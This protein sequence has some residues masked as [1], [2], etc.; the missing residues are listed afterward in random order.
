MIERSLIDGEFLT[1]SG[2]DHYVESVTT[3]AYYVA[4]AFRGTNRAGLVA[5]SSLLRDQ[6]RKLELAPRKGIGLL[7]VLGEVAEVVL[8]NSTVVSHPRYA[9]HLHCP[10]TVSSL[11]AETVI[12]ALNQSMDSYDQGPVATVIEQY[13]VDWICQLLGY[14]SGEGVFT[15][16]ATQSN[17]Q[18]LLLA[19]DTYAREH[20][21]WNTA[22][23]GLPT[24]ARRWRII[25]TR[26]THFTVDLAAR[27]LG[28]GSASIVDA[29]TDDQ[30]RLEPRSLRS[31]IQRCH[32]ARLPVIAVVLNAGTTDRGVIDPLWESCMIAQ[33][34]GIWVHVDA[35]AGG[36]LMFS[37]KHR[38][39]LDGISTSDA[40]AID[41]HKLLFQSISCGALL[42]RRCWTLETLTTHVDYL[43]PADDD[44]CETPNLVGK[45]LQTTRRFDALKV[46]VTLRALGV[47]AIAHMIECTIEA[48]HAASRAAAGD[49]RLRVIGKA[50]TNT[51]LIRW[52]SSALSPQAL[53]R[54][55]TMVCQRLT[56]DGHALI[57]RTRVKQGV[58]LKLTFVNPICTAETAKALVEEIA[59]LGDSIARDERRGVIDDARADTAS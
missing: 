12:S 36:C 15:S 44:P 18:A 56:T 16:G 6:I 4:N 29:D 3:A 21:S 19:R 42:V 45:S 25:S 51:V 52:V 58:A 54:V 41:F 31:A 2:A 55:N 53:D 46:F 24:V 13:V 43:N 22:A 50:V 11:A 38:H 33:E 23:D 35:A 32:A 40:I 14:A 34:H 1:E 27:L 39:L 26:Q 7:T 17:L 9:A 10:P 5:G 49:E 28:L 57:G 59:T 20:L 37:D 30:G 48:A 8:P 47:D